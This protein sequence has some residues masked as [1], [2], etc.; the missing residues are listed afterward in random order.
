MQVRVPTNRTSG[1]A[2]PK[3]FPQHL[4][5]FKEKAGMS[6]REL[7]M[8]VGVSYG[9]SD[10]LAQGNGPKGWGLAQSLSRGF[11]HAGRPED[12]GPGRCLAPVPGK[13]RR[14]VGPWQGSVG[15]SGQSHSASRRT[16]PSDWSGSRRRG[17]LTWRSLARLL[18]VSPYRLRR[19]R[20]GTVPD[21]TR[22][23]LMLTVA[24][25]MGL[26]EGILMCADLDLPYRNLEGIRL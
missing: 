3:E 13:W 18:G 12:A 9:A 19:W 5:L 15:H 26:R 6:W 23:F 25:D 16:S 2:L 7:A 1:S 20:Q 24:E 4:E 17:G 11:D 10:E 14:G 22:L 8:R 21:S